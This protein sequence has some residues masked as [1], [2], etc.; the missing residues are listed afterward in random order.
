MN[1]STKSGI[2]SGVQLNIDSKQQHDSDNACRDMEMKC[3]KYQELQEHDGEKMMDGHEGSPAWIN[4]STLQLVESNGLDTSSEQKAVQLVVPQSD[5]NCCTDKVSAATETRTHE[6]E[7]LLE[8]E[9]GAE[10]NVQLPEG[11][12]WDEEVH[13]AT[14]TRFVEPAVLTQAMQRPKSKFRERGGVELKR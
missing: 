11:K 3:T 9:V 13:A 14:M 12:S 1:G 6:G 5:E 7:E 2:H 4:S 10:R 8:V